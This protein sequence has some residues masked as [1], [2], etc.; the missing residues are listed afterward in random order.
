MITA[1]SVEQQALALMPHFLITRGPQQGQCIPLD[2]ERLTAQPLVLGRGTGEAE[3]ALQSYG[4]RVSRR[5]ALV[6]YRVEDE[7]LTLADAGSAN[8]T[9]VN[10]EFIAGL[11]PLLPGD[12]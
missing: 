5:H 4:Q 11:M 9:Q 3:I 10:G 12:T 2:F 8:G 1:S 6:G 7:R